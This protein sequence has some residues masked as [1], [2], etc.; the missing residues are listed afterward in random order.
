M[1]ITPV[2]SYITPNAGTIVTAVNSFASPTM[3]AITAGNNVCG[4]FE[5]VSGSGTLGTI[6]DNAGSPN[7]YNQS[8]VLNNADGNS[9]VLFRL[10]NVQGGPT[11][12]TANFDGTNQLSFN[13]FVITEF[14][15]G[16]RTSALDVGYGGPTNNPGIV[17]AATFSSA[18]VTTL[19]AGDLIY[20]VA[21]QTNAST[22]VAAGANYTSLIYGANADVVPMRAEYRIQAS[23]GSV[24]TGN[25]QFAGV[26][27]TNNYIAGMIPLKAA[28]GGAVFSDSGS[29]GDLSL[30]VRSG[31]ERRRTVW[32]TRGGL[33]T[34]TQPLLRRSR[35]IVPAGAM[36]SVVPG[37]SLGAF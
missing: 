11:I 9:L 25:A 36:R 34:P 1:A 13:R 8:P 37:P 18:D 7:T 24:N 3:T 32:S 15:G 5:F 12:I 6:V 22:G 4:G 14:S 35:I 23:A 2:H 19:V 21:C 33:F 10:E 29:V 26:S 28:V 16:A 20:C 31:N 27:G 17:G 30:A